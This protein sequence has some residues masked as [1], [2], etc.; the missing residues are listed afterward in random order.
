[1]GFTS[2]KLGISWGFKQQ[3]VESHGNYD[4]IYYQDYDIRLGLN[5]KYHDVIPIDLM[6]N[7]MIDHGILGY[8]IFSQIHN[9]FYG[10]L[11]NLCEF[12]IAVS[13]IFPM[14]DMIWM[15]SL[16]DFLSRGL[17]SGMS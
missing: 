6:G 10:I 16:S 15:N 5:G 3:N 8:P 14:S 13:C 2:K 7:M 17:I 9:I 11:M 1:M 4:G 12:S